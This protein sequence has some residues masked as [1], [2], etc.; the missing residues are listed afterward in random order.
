M[1]KCA[2]KEFKRIQKGLKRMKKE[3]DRVSIVRD[4]RLSDYSGVEKKIESVWV[5]RNHNRA[6]HRIRPIDQERCAGLP[7]KPSPTLPTVQRVRGQ[8]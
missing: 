4:G 6:S 8:F 3:L 1:E 7:P 5:G 2:Q